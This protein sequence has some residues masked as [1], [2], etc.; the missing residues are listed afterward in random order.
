MWEEKNASARPPRKEKFPVPR[1]RGA[2]TFLPGMPGKRA[3]HRIFSKISPSILDTRAS[4]VHF[5]GLPQMNPSLLQDAERNIEFE[6]VRATENA[7]LN[8]MHWIGRG[9]KEKADEAACDAI[10][11]VFDL[12]DIRGEVVIGEG[13]KDKAPG[14]FLG[15]RL[16][17]CGADAPRFDI[18]L[19]PVDGTSNV[20]KGLPN[21]ISVMAAA[22]VPK[23]QPHGMVNIPSFYVEKIAYGPETCEAIEAGRVAPISLD[24]PF[25]LT[26]TTVAGA[27]HKR[28]SDLV[29]VVLDRPRNARL[30]EA[31]RRVGASL[32]MIADGDIAAAVAPALPDSGVDIYAGIGGA[33]EGIL[34]AAALKALGGEILVRMWPRDDAERA[35]LLRSVSEAD[36]R[37]VWRRDDLVVGPSALFCA[38]G[39]SDSA[40][41]PG[42]KLVGTKAIT[43]SILMRAR[44]QT[45]RYIRAVHDLNKKTIHLRS[46]QREAAV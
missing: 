42:V 45:V 44:S 24:D 41:L 5:S 10:N 34:T 16:G 21:S 30:I 15:D 18:A 32:R 20:S 39:I 25:D 38:T 19:D 8:C 6:F 3:G 37:R 35:D 23:G 29:V 11:G 1:L 14:I 4:D 17:R 12:V 27:M 7:A 9:E 28:L 36:L 43:H 22:H 33:P 46:I 2:R 40:L 26:L 13:I 31:A